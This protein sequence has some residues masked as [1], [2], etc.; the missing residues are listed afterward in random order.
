MKKFYFLI[1][2]VV[3]CISCSSD[4]SSDS[5]NPN[6]LQR[7]DFFP[8]TVYE[9]RL[10]FNTDGLL[11]QISQADGTIIKSFTYDN[12]NRL[13]SVTLYNSDPVTTNTFEYDSN[14][15]VSSINGQPLPYNQTT[16]SYILGDVNT[17]YTENKI[18]SDKLLTYTKNVWIDVDEDGNPLEILNSELGIVYSNNNMVSYF[19]NESCNYFTF[20]NKINPLRNATIAISIAFSAYTS[21]PWVDINSISA[22]N[23]ITHSYCTEDPESYVFHY[24]YNS[25]NLPITQT[26]DDYYL[27]VYESTITSINYY[28]QGDVLP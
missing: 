20:D 1:C 25:N 26:R 14:G 27:G 13:A 15:F 11:Y 19:P 2:F 24:T 8:G 22:N 23:I 21:A 5:L 4:S 7:V 17:F 16:Q 9:T 10:L 28:Y 3:V 18:N 6:L 12:Q